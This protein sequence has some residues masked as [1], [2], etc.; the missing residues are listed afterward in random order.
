[1]RKL[2]IEILVGELIVGYSIVTIVLQGGVQDIRRITSF[3]NSPAA[4][5]QTGT[6]AATDEVTMIRLMVTVLT[7]ADKTLRTRFMAGLNMSRS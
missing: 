1:M 5:S 4:S 6:S 7:A 3:D 2:G